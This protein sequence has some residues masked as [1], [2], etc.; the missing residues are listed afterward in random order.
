M[1]Y[2]RTSLDLA[3]NL[4]FIWTILLRIRIILIGSN[5]DPALA[6]GTVPY[7]TEIFR[8]I[9]IKARLWIQIQHGIR[10]TPARILARRIRIR[11]KP[12]FNKEPGIN[13]ATFIFNYSQIKKLK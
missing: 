6:L 9:F 7:S 10:L 11:I 13:M 5:L 3:K 1:H 8:E 4:V 2:Y 12:D